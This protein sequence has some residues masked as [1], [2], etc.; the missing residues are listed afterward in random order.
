[1]AAKTLRNLAYFFARKSVVIESNGM[2]ESFET[3]CLFIFNG[4]ERV[5]A[6]SEPMDQNQNF[7]LFPNIRL[8]ILSKV[9]SIVGKKS[10]KGQKNYLDRKCFCI[11]LH[12]HYY[13]SKL[14]VGIYIYISVCRSEAT[15]Q[16]PLFAV[17]FVF[18]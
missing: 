14:K 11:I 3:K 15:L 9:L 17:L 4:L 5:V 16:N 6:D 1:M 2:I 7:V 12:F 13:G 18:R 8:Q 10:Q